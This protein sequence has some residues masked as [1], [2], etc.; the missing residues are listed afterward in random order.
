MFMQ[1]DNL[2]IITLKETQNKIIPICMP[3]P[4]L[5]QPNSVNII[6]YGGD[7]NQGGA[8]GLGVRLLNQLIEENYE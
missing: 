4:I 7:L 6:G 8:T 3:D 2:A 1:M 5:S